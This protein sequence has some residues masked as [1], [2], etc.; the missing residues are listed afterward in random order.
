MAPVRDRC[1]VRL[2]VEFHAPCARHPTQ[3]ALASSQSSHSDL[4]QG[5]ASIV[6]AHTIPW[7]DTAELVGLQKRF[8]WCIAF[9]VY[10]TT[11]ARLQSEILLWQQR[12]NNV[13]PEIDLSVRVQIARPL[14]VLDIVYRVVAFCDQFD[15]VQQLTGRKFP[16]SDQHLVVRGQKR[17]GWRL[18]RMLKELWGLEFCMTVRVSGRNTPTL[19]GN[20]TTVR[21]A[22]LYLH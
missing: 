16:P 9:G 2:P 12:R 17:W 6:L 14:A 18:D 19:T 15:N 3:R 4:A 22:C 7:T 13:Q 5:W 11:P 8:S 10:V 21:I 1:H 20:N